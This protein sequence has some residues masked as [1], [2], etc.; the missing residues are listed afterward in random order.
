MKMYRALLLA[1]MLALS[2]LDGVA[3]EKQIVDVKELAG[4]WRGW[5]A[6]GAGDEWG[7]VNVSAD[8]SYK[9]SGNRGSRRGVL[10]RGVL[11]LRRAGCLR[12]ARATH[13]PEF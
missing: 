1:A 10:V 9:T 13:F 6:E 4:T 8:G 2:A 11:A 5:G 12:P 3:G 7:A